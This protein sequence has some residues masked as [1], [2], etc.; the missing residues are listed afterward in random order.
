MYK[1][2][3]TAETSLPPTAGT[4][5]CSEE[6]AGGG[7]Q[8]LEEPRP[9]PVGVANREGEAGRQSPTR[10]CPPPSSCST[11]EVEASASQRSWRTLQVAGLPT[12]LLGAELP[13]QWRRGE[14]REGGRKVGKL[15]GKGQP[16][17]RGAEE[18]LIPRRSG[19][20]IN[21]RVYT[22]AGSLPIWPPSLSR[23]GFLS[24]PASHVLAGSQT[25]SLVC[26]A[27][28]SISRRSRGGGGAQRPGSPAGPP[29]VGFR[30]RGSLVGV[31]AAPTPP[32]RPQLYP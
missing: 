1:E 18:T 13:E 21:L 32:G 28:G 16:S 19:S 4:E 6:P 17:Q 11:W 5:N 23:V 30:R 20:R 2:D 15:P 8:R 29:S 9:A 10:R 25:R 3:S 27:G 14:H 22:G 12:A 24:S 7:E 26:G 31:A